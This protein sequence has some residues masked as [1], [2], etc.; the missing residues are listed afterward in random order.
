LGR[1]L[2]KSWPLAAEE[3]AAHFAW[4]FA[5]DPTCIG[6]QTDAGVAAFP[7]SPSLSSLNTKNFLLD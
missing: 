2:S 5:S 3:E 7:L 1:E 6:G 4:S